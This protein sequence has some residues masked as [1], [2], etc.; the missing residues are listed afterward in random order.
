MKK[1]K[2][3]LVLLL[4]I[5]AVGCSS[6]NLAVT[7]NLTGSA[8]VSTHDSTIML[9]QRGTIN[10]TTYEKVRAI[11]LQAQIKY[12]DASILLEKYLNGETDNLTL[13]SETMTA[14]S[15]LLVDIAVWMEEK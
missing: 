9:H 1:H 15:T 7:H 5:S 14:I 11:W 10:D 4:I 3:L 8:L 12:I 13:Y 6:V 2:I